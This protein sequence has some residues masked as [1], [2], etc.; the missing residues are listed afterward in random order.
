MIKA[1]LDT[2]A[3]LH[4]M[5][6]IASFNGERTVEAGRGRDK[7]HGDS[8]LINAINAAIINPASIFLNAGTTN[9][10]CRLGRRGCAKTN[11]AP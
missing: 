6:L 2:T 5:K 1:A 3:A 10:A 7:S 11:Y 9:C 4:L 8:S